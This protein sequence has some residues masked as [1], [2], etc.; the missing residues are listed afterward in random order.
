MTVGFHKSSD[1]TARDLYRDITKDVAPP[2]VLERVG[3]LSLTF[4]PWSPE[5]YEECMRK[6]RANFHNNA[7]C[8]LNLF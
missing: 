1:P 5:L 2:E 8:T 6:Q 3:K 4:S 7:V